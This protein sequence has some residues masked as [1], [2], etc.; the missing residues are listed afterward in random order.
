MTTNQLITEQDLFNYIWHPGDLATNKFIF[1]FE[2]SDEYSI[3][4]KIL[5]DSYKQKNG[6][7]SFTQ[8]N[9]ILKRIKNH[10]KSLMQNFNQF[11]FN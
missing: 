3:P 8:K 2:H 1:I 11:N 5:I 4:L 7:I 9:K 6:K 10:Y